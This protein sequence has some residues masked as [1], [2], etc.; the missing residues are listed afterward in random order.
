MTLINEIYLHTKKK[1][2]FTKMFVII[3]ILSG[4]ITKY[5]NTKEHTT[6]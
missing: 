6:L 3:L 1:S 5:K 2:Y 4:K